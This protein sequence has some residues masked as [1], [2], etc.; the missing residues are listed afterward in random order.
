LAALAT[1]ERTTVVLEAPT[2]LAGTLV[3]LAA[4]L[5]DRPVAV[6]RELTKVHEEVWRGRLGD[7]AVELADREARGEAIRGEIVVVVG[8]APPPL[9]AGDDAVAAAVAERLAAGDSPRQAADAVAGDLD[10]PRRRAYEMAI[11][12]RDQGR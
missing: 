9:Q 10:V 8:G 3:E 5:G 11:D 7:A 4:T 1:E 6:A 12:L 2:R